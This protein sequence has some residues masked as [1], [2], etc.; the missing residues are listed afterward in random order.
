MAV[1][2]PP[3]IPLCLRA[4][5]AVGEAGALMVLLLTWEGALSLMRLVAEFGRWRDNAIVQ[6]SLPVLLLLGRT[7]VGLVRLPG[8]KE[9]PQQAGG[10]SS[11][12]PR[13]AR[14]VDLSHCPHI[15]ALV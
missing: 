8:L 14:R 4:P 9:A 6:H 15:P 12:V 10:S 1:A 2:G 5:A 3:E 11:M 7:M 13:E